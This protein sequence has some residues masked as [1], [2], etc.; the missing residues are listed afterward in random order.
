MLEEL[1]KGFRMSGMN[2]SVSR[3]FEHAWNRVC[4]HS[5]R[6]E[7]VYGQSEGSSGGDRS[8]VLQASTGSVFEE[9]SKCFRKSRMNSSVS[10]HFEQQWNRVCSNSCRSGSVYGQCEG[11]SGVDRSGILLLG[12]SC[13]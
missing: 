7:S 9:L 4:W 6:S 8:S 2:S 13:P 10:K 3:H 1:S 12:V 5:R 11:S